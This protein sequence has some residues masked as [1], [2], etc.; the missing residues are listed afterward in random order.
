LA[1]P[2]TSSVTTIQQY[3]QGR[4][5]S[6]TGVDVKLLIILCFRTEKYVK[7]VVRSLVH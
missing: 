4:S 1:S 3:T 6:M 2:R 7:R 5:T